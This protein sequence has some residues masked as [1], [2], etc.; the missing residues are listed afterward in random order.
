MS[1]PAPKDVHD[2]FEELL[3]RKITVSLTDPMKAADTNRAMV[4]LYQDESQRMTAVA[5]LDLTLAVYLGAALGLIPVGGAQDSI[6]EGK[7]F[8][9]IAENVTE[10][11]NV[12]VGLFN[13]RGAAHVRMFQ[14]FLPGE[15]VPT[16][17]TNLLTA[18]GRRLD[19]MIE[20]S[21]YGGGKLSL[22]RLF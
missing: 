9:N 7:L 21:G 10:V 11:C 15:G 4:A 17:A 14:R 3:G 5:G 16:D 8:P 20:V 1:L 13:G 22:S 19:L 12:M 2:L 6:D 18:L